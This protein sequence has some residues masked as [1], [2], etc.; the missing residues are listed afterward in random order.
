MDMKG[1]HTLQTSLQ[2]IAKR[3]RKD[4]KARIGNVYGLLNVENLRECFY[5]LRKKAAPGV[6]KVT[7]KDYEENLEQNL[8]DLNE[9]LKCKRYRARLVRREYIPKGDGTSRP[10]GIP[11][12]EDKLL[13]LAAAKVLVAIYEELF[14]P[15]N[16]G[17]RPGSNARETSRDLAEKFIYGNYAWVVDA[18]IEGFFDHVNHDWM[19]RMLT[20]RIDD[21]SFLRLIRK[22]LK[23]GVLE[24][25]GKVISP[26]SGTPQGGVISPILANIYLHYVLDLWFEK[27]VKQRLKGG[28]MMI[29]YADDFVVAFEHEEDARRFLDN[30]PGR[31]GKFGLK[32]SKG[33]TQ[34][35]RFKRGDSLNNGG[36]DFLGFRYNWERT[37][38]GKWKVQ[39]HTASKR[40]KRS[41]KRFTDWVKL[42]RH[43]PLPLLMTA[44]CRKLS[45]YW[46]Y[47]GVIGNFHCLRQFWFQVERGLYKWL[48]RRSQKRSI[49]WE[50]LNRLIKHYK[51]PLPRITES[52][53][54]LFDFMRV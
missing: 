50:R 18:D 35:V 4:H 36:F 43:K 28:C 40:L 11:V 46:Q 41:I 15:F 34:L 31:L 29:R 9:R 24:K 14:L 13:Q 37:R 25:D 32:L 2:G 33:K 3:I 10:L 30:L 39:R 16:R 7:F 21:K 52:R 47:Y 22:W 42:N 48:N 26:T 38:K 12:L 44:L 51:I 17:Y 5:E 6:D 27:V 8:E 19:I 53:Q 23:A 49:T 20:E 45:G 54:Q 1:H